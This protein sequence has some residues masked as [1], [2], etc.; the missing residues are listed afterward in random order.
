MIEG[1]AC[2]LSQDVHEKF[3]YI[4]AGEVLEHLPNPGLFLAEAARCLKPGGALFVT[5]PNAF[6]LLRIIGLFQGYESVHKDHC[7]YFSGKTLARLAALYGFKLERIGYTD[8]LVSARWKPFLS[9]AWQQLIQHM[10]VFGQS[11]VA[12]LRF[13]DDRKLSCRIL[14]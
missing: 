1:D 12:V 11:V 14:D 3:D 8:P 13:G 9:W 4:V 5:V 6:N 7:F 10:P 2:Q